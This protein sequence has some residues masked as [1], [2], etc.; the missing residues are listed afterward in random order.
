MY[1]DKDKIKYIVIDGKPYPRHRMQPR[2]KGSTDPEIEKADSVLRKEM[3]DI[4]NAKYRIREKALKKKKKRIEF[5]EK[6][7]HKDN[8]LIVNAMKPNSVDPNQITEDIKEGQKNQRE[9]VYNTWKPILSG[10]DA[11]INVSTLLFPTNRYV[12]SANVLS[13]GMQ[14]ADDIAQKKN[15]GSSATSLALDGIGGLG[16]INKLPVKRDKTADTAGF[17]GNVKDILEDGKEL[18]N[19]GYDYY[20]NKYNSIGFKPFT[21]NYYRKK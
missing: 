13:D 16:L 4:K 15:I 18:Y 7:A 2:P 21:D 17:V 3:S 5:A 14:L 20:N 19:S 9:K 6:K 10:A 11:A 1:G 8:D 12:F